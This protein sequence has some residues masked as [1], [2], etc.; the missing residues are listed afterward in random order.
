M[1]TRV[2]KR[3]SVTFL[4]KKEGSLSTLAM[5]YGNFYNN[6]EE[7]V[8]ARLSLRT[9]MD[10]DHYVKLREYRDNVPRIHCSQFMRLAL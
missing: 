8:L 3:I 9:N 7:T 1:N 5:K 4:M 10:Q 6:N 2:R